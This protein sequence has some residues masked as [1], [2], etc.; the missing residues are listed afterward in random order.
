MGAIYLFAGKFSYIVLNKAVY[1]KVVEMNTE[2]RQCQND[3]GV[4]CYIGSEYMMAQ[5][6]CNVRD[7]TKKADE[8]LMYQRSL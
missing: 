1:E 8:A 7:F 4:F 3:P 2:R 5:Y 6:R